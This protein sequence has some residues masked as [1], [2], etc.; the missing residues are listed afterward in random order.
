[1]SP[2]GQAVIADM[3]KQAL[4]S[5]QNKMASAGVVVP[6]ATSF[7][8]LGQSLASAHVPWTNGQT[9]PV[10]KTL[11]VKKDSADI[12]LTISVQQTAQ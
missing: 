8:Q 12:T 4:A 6:T 5:V 11:H 1:M 9:Q 7:A 3:Q 10:N 2:A